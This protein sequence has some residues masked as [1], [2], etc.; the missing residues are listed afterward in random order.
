M[1]RIAIIS[2]VHGNITA[3]NTVLDDIAVRGISRIFCLGD[4][5]TKCA[6]PDLVIDALRENC[7][8]MIKGNCDE[9]IC[10]P[11]E[12]AKRFWSRRKIG[13][14]RANYI[15]NLPVSYDFYM[16]GRL[17]RLFHASPQSLV[18]IFN[19]MYSNSENSHADMELKDPMDL[20]A[21]TEFI[22]KTKDSP[23]P[24]VVGYGH[25]HTP[26][27]FRI[28]NKTVFNPGSVGAPIE[29]L[30]DDP[31]DKTNQFSTVASYIILEGK[32]DSR[33]LMPINFNLVRL[34]YDIEEEVK[35]LEQSKLPSRERLIA[36]LRSATNCGDVK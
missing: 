27:I 5:V 22:G 1:E 20:F 11:S 3:L 32:F 24:D 33:E 17:I 28:R 21:N 4:S 25:I 26:N 15:Y 36:E 14:E 16:S 18:H 23:V 30:N 10:Q 35:L 19:P 34:P 9:I 6:N 29:M 8:V 7:E 2:D 12:N 13:E 31:F